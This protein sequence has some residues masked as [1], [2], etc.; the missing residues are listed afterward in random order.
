MTLKGRI[1]AVASFAAFVAMVTIFAKPLWQGALP[2]EGS[3]T[4]QAAKPSDRWRLS[5]GEQRSRSSHND[6]SGL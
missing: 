2:N 4:S 6:C 5:A 1:V 3:Q